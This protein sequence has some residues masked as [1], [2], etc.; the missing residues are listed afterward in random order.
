MSKYKFIIC[1]NES[2]RLNSV[3]PCI[4]NINSKRNKKL[5]AKQRADKTTLTVELEPK[6]H[7][8][9]CYMCPL[10]MPEN[11]NN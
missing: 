8:N 11:H 7:G 5:T 1:T 9:L 4:N 6:S 3:D 10:Y 2:C